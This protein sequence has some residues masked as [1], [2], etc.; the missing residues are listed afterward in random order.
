MENIRQTFLIFLWGSF[1]ACINGIIFCFLIKHVLS[2]YSRKICQNKNVQNYFS[3]AQKGLDKFQQ[4][5]R[6]RKHYSGLRI[7]PKLIQQ[8]KS[9]LSRCSQLMPII[10][11]NQLK[12]DSKWLHEKQPLWWW[13]KSYAAVNLFR[14]WLHDK[15]FTESFF[16]AAQS[17]GKRARELLTGVF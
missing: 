3:Q 11:S 13:T 4:F 15:T 8:I 6:S 10:I 16:L 17:N 2:F 14:G 1:T 5:S 9:T 12:Y 7:I